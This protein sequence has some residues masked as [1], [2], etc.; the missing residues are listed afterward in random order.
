MTIKKINRYAPILHTGFFEKHR[1]GAVEE[2]A[3]AAAARGY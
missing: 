3:A 2:Y 1:E